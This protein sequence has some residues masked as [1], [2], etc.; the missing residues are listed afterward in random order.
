M[1]QQ[2]GVAHQVGHVDGRREDLEQERPGDQ[3]VGDTAGSGT[4]PNVVVLP[5]PFGPR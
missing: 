3:P 5:A 4:H 1:V 2:R